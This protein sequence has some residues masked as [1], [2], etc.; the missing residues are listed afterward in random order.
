M[1]WSLWVNTS[2][3]LPQTKRFTLLCVVEMQHF[4]DF[5]SQYAWETKFILALK[6]LCKPHYTQHMQGNAYE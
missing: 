1:T 3:N 6:L 4:Q 2:R 5:K